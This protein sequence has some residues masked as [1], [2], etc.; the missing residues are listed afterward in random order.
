MAGPPGTIAYTI[1]VARPRKVKSRQA[2]TS[3]VKPARDRENRATANR[4]DQPSWHR[5]R[6]S[7]NR[8]A[9]PSPAC[10][11]SDSVPLSDVASPAAGAVSAGAEFKDEPPTD[12]EPVPAP[13]PDEEPV[14][15]GVVKSP[16]GGVGVR[17]SPGAT[18]ELPLPDED[19]P[20]PAPRSRGRR[21]GLPV[22]PGRSEDVP[23]AT[24]DPDDVPDDGCATEL[25]DDVDGRRREDELDAPSS[26][27][28]AG[29]STVDAPAADPVPVLDGRAF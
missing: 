24:D 26:E 23:G 17:L 19:P 9:G 22:E 5:F 13:V 20:V 18:D 15:G 4:T 10:Y 2:Y 14:P 12:E 29:E 25:L 6:S 28:P 27:P 7:K 16:P 1:V 3:K 8:G 11:G 21:D